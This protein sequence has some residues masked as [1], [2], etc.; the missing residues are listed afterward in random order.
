MSQEGNHLVLME[1]QAQL[2]KS[3]LAASLV[4]FGQLV[5]AHDQWKV[6]GLLL[7]APHLLCRSQGGK[8]PQYFK[9]TLMLM[10]SD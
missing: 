8:L 1:V 2:V 10:L 3:Q 9:I 4:D 5:D 7:D 6:A